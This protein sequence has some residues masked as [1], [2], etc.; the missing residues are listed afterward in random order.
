ME[1]NLMTGVK[2][3]LANAR[4]L[5]PGM[6]KDMYLLTDYMSENVNDN[7]VPIGFMRFTALVQNDLEKG[8]NGFAGNFPAEL[9]A[10]KD[11]VLD[12]IKWIPQVVDAIANE[13][14]ANEFR[15]EW[16][17]VYH[18][19]P[20]K[21]LNTSSIATDSDYL[22]YIKAAVDW[23]ANAIISPKFDNGEAL[24]TFLS[25]LMAG[26]QKSY[27]A[28]EIKIFKEELAKRIATEL[29][30]FNCCNLDVDYGP[31]TILDEVGQKIGVTMYPCKTYM[32]ITTECVTV[33][34]GYGSAGEELY[35]A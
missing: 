32:K 11:F 14:F 18:T 21:R 17:K 16:E 19:V 2:E 9:S 25:F 12:E 6:S 7:L 8:R 28:E 35:K 15:S 22:P 31:C 29:E 3:K 23:W 1:K 4:Q 10:R 5:C 34:A 13:D 20:P 24:P 27:S 33:H 30:K 26:S